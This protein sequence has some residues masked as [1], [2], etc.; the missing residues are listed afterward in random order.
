MPI[1]TSLAELPSSLPNQKGSVAFVPT[2]GAL[3]KGHLSLIEEAAQ[4]CDKVVVSIFVN[5]AQFAPC[6]DFER[7]PRTLDD[8]VAAA[9]AAGAT[10]IYAPTIEEVYPNY[11]DIEPLRDSDGQ[12]AD[13]KQV[14]G[15]LAT[16]WEGEVRPGHFEGVVAVVKRLFDLVQP[17]YAYFGEKDYQQ[18]RIIENMVQQLKLPT[19]IVRCQTVRD[20]KGLALSSRNRYLSEEEYQIA[21]TIPAALKTAAIDRGDG[22]PD[23]FLKSAATTLDENIRIDYF[24]AVDGQTLEPLQEINSSPDIRILFA[25]YVGSTRLIDNVAV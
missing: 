24:V 4:T 15:T 17:D 1:L 11:P 5:P 12:L 16:R 23:T 2:M 7:Y 18:L 8:D 6:E 13:I 20:D 10:H 9:R 3:H 19:K 22:S 21:L 14:L 25:G